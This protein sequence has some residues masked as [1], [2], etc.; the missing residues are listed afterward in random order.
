MNRRGREG[1]KEVAVAP[2]RALALVQGTRFH[3]KVGHLWNQGW[4]C[5]LQTWQ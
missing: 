5:R 4:A 1:E 2:P 3:F